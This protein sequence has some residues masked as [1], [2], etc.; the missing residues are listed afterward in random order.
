MKL[1]KKDLLKVYDN[2]SEIA[3]I[4]RLNED[5]AKL[6]ERYLSYIAMD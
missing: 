2:I 3:A 5:E 6:L 4:R 1:L